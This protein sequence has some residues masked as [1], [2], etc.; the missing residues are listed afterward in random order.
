MNVPEFILPS[1]KSKW[2]SPFRTDGGDHIDGEPCSRFGHDRR[3]TSRCP[4]GASVVIR[5]QRCLVLEE[6]SRSDARSL[7]PE[8]R[9][10]PRSSIAPQLPGSAGT[11]GTADAAVSCSSCAATH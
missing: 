2:M 8:L 5:L 9:V 4:G 10:T 11:P 3:L 7:G 1:N 6:D